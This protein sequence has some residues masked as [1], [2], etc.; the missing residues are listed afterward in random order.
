[1]VKILIMD[2]E[3]GL[4]NI[5]YNMLKPLGYPLFTAEDGH[6]AIE[7]AKREIPDLAML[8]M[9]VP[10]MDGLEALAELKKI[11]PNIKAIMLS[12]FGDVDS[13][14]EALKKGANEY[15]SKPFKVDEVLAAVRKTI[16][17]ITG[18]A[19]P[20]APQGAAAAAPAPAP[21]K[22]VV[23]PEP[24]KP[25]PAPVPA[26]VAVPVP[27][28][29]AGGSKKIVMLA[30]AVVVL[31]VLVGGGLFA[32]KS[33]LIGGASSESFTIPY[34]NQSSVTL[35]RPFLWIT[36]ASTGNIYKHNRDAS[37]SIDSIYKTANSQPTGITFDGQS[38]WTCSASKQ[39]IYRHKVDKELTIEAIFA[40]ANSNPSSLYYDAG[41]LWVLDSAAGKIYKHKTDEAL[42]P[43]GEY[44][45]PAANPC[46]M[47]RNG[48][49]FYIG[50][51]RTGKMFKVSASDFA[52][53]EVYAMPNFTNGKYKMTNVAWDGKNIWASTENAGK[54][55][56][57]P[58]TSLKPV[59]F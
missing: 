15:I 46:G 57:I 47:F 17:T 7:I 2:D 49:F 35:I 4:R 23:V 53:T 42:T 54:I 34:T 38:I 31:A 36:D 37:L 41:N 58:L 22:K 1:M 40:T 28:A 24:K 44:T 50:D 3:P 39:R 33:G 30:A 32:W 12:G 20:A 8:D 48:E 56:R 10:D 25:A 6:Q 18:E 19:V 14:I 45:S 27:G 5:V 16:G 11:N 29:A 52:V 13:A 51:A 26:P 21:V 59:E 55:I 9:R 43:E